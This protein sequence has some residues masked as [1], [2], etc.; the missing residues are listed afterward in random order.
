MRLIFFRIAALTPRT[1]TWET[2]PATIFSFMHLVIEHLDQLIRLSY[3]K[4]L[5]KD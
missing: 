2:P 5:T 1:I 4:I 3:D